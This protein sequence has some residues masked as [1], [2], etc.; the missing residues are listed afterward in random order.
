MDIDKC[1]WNM[2]PEKTH[3]GC[4]SGYEV[5]EGSNS[6]LTGQGCV[7]ADEFL[8]KPVASPWDATSASECA[9]FQVID[10]AEFQF[11]TFTLYKD[12]PLTKTWEECAQFCLEHTPLCMGFIWNK[13]TDF[14]D[15]LRCRKVIQKSFLIFNFPI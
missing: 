11:S 3:C 10:G 9:E 12:K 8:V 7:Q 14:E 2:D 6:S 1:H 5:A 4:I 15:P 13:P